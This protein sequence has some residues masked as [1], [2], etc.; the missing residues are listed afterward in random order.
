MD[1]SISQPNPTTNNDDY[2]VGD[3][4]LANIIG[5]DLI[6]MKEVMVKVQKP[7]RNLSSSKQEEEKNLAN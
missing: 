6:Y 3:P 7:V 2:H 5:R 1:S 4:A